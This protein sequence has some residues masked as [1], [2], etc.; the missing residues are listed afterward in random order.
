MRARSARKS[1]NNVFG[2]FLACVA[3]RWLP[4]KKIF[5]YNTRMVYTLLIES[6][7]FLFFFWGCLVSRSCFVPS[8]GRVVRSASCRFVSWS[9]SVLSVRVRPSSR[10]LS[11]WV[12]S[13]SFSSPA[14]AGSFASLWSRRLPAVCRGCVVRS[15]AGRFLVSVPVARG[16]GLGL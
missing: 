6:N 16:L 3:V 7:Y 13:V 1:I 5:A 8:F 9:S 10:S 11:G 4:V 15:A 12:C 2:G 14:A